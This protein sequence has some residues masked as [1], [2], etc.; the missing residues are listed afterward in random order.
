MNP[1]LGVVNKSS[2][3]FKRLSHKDRAKFRAAIDMTDVLGSNALRSAG[4]MIVYT[5]KST[6]E[7]GLMPPLLIV[8]ANEPI[9]SESQ[10]LLRWRQ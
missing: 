9:N 1:K 6:S 4:W 7:S 10:A 2:S 8:F 3:K 5:S